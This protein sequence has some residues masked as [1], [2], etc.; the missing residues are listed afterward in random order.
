MSSFPFSSLRSVIGLENSSRPIK[1]KSCI[2]FFESCVLFLHS[3]WFRVVITCTFSGIGFTT[4]DW[5]CLFS[6]RLVNNTR[7]IFLTHQMFKNKA[8]RIKLPLSH[9][10]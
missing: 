1:R 3:D 9:V 7:A 2:V 10:R 8:V 6:P 5:S 4:F